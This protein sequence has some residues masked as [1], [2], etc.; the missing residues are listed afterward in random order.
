MQVI[1]SPAL[2]NQITTATAGGRDTRGRTAQA[3]PA[4]MVSTVLLIL[5]EA[6]AVGATPALAT[7]WDPARPT[8]SVLPATPT[9][10]SHPVVSALQSI[11][12]TK[13]PSTFSKMSIL[14]QT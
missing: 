14:I 7:P 1:D 4:V 10:P 5:E 12:P 9:L 8:T 11:I 3:T 13:T 6:Q 2:A